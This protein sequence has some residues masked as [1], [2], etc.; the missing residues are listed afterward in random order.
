MGERRGLVLDDHTYMRQATRNSLLEAGVGQVDEVDS[1]AALRQHLTA[2]RAPDIAIVDLRLPDGSALD[3]IPE[4]KAR[5]TKVVVFT[6]ADDGYTVRAAYAAGASGYLLK[7]SEHSAV[8]DALTEVLAG[9]VH[10]DPAVAGLLVAGVQASPTSAGKP[11]SDRELSILQLA[12]DGMSNAEIG[13]ALSITAL[14][15]KG[16]FVRIG[17]KLGATDRTAMVA[18]AL[19]ADLLR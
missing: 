13:M 3:L 15:V 16:H 1:L 2:Q 7:S 18:E 4:L 5:G 17:R 10:V 11:L 14:A 6:S 8:V 12:A 9:K 19:R